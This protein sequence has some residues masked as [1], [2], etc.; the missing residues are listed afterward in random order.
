MFIRRIGLAA[1]ALAVGSAA[2]A[3]TLINQDVESGAAS[4][5]RIVAESGSRLGLQPMRWL[6]EGVAR[7]E[8]VDFT[9][10]STNG[11]ARFVEDDYM[12]LR[13][14]GVRGALSGWAIGLSVND[15]PED[16]GLTF[17]FREPVNAFGLE[18]GDWA[19]CCH[20]SALYIAFDGGARREV[21]TAYRATDNPGF[22]TYGQFTSFVGAFDTGGS[23]TRVSFYGAGIGEYM[24][25]GGTIRYASLPLEVPQR[26][27]APD[28]AD[29]ATVPEPSTWALVLAAWLTAQ[30]SS[31]HGHRRLVARARAPRSRRLGG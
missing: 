22:V 23:Y 21:A 8:F 27:R 10:T 17:E 19:T 6:R 12:A 28:A 31:H 1:G 4:F 20:P 25:G 26:R 14:H 2:A 9:I 29:V 16:W 24:V 15:P 3:P 13:E 11:W 7:W 30:A 5:D 18:V